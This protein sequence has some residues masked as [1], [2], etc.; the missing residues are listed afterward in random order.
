MLAPLP[1]CADGFG[2]PAVPCGATVGIVAVTADQARASMRSRRG[3]G[4]RRGVRRGFRRNAAPS[5]GSTVCSTVLR[6]ASL[7]VSPR[8]RGTSILRCSRDSGQTC[9]RENDRCLAALNLADKSDTLTRSAS[10]TATI[11]A[12][13]IVL[14]VYSQGTQRQET[15][16]ALVGRAARGRRGARGRPRLIGVLDPAEERAMTP[17]PRRA[18]TGQQHRCPASD[19]HVAGDCL[20][21]GVC[22]VWYAG[23]ELARGQARGVRDRQHTAHLA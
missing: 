3:S 20:G 17:A 14:T 15:D 5:R 7:P 12:K 6:L 4:R 1:A 11:I 8:A 9:C 21:G 2:Q 13:G 16:P 23:R 19:S 22:A 18:V 10:T